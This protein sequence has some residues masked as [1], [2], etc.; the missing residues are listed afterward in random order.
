MYN[1]ESFLQ[2][3]LYILYWDWEVVLLSLPW[4]YLLKNIIAIRWSVE[5][6]MPDFIQGIIFLEVDFWL[7]DMMYGIVSFELQGIK[8]TCNFL[9]SEQPIVER[10]NVAILQISDPRRRSRVNLFK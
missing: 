4:N 6:V 7:I 8:I 10:R 1:T 3:L 2:N 5:N 9:F